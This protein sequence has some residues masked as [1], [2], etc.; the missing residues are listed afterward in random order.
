MLRSRQIMHNDVG[1][2]SKEAQLAGS[3]RD[4]QKPKRHR[5]R[6]LAATA[7]L[8]AAVSISAAGC[9]NSIT[10]PQPQATC[11]QPGTINPL[12]PTCQPN[13]T[14]QI[15][16]VP[17]TSIT[18]STITTTTTIPAS[19]PS[20][21]ERTNAVLRGWEDIFSHLSP[22]NVRKQIK[23][24]RLLIFL[25]A[26]GLALYGA[27]SGLLYA[28]RRFLASEK[29][30]ASTDNE[31]YLRHIVHNIILPGPVRAA[32]L[33]PHT[34]QDVLSYLAKHKKMG[35]AVSAAFNESISDSDFEK[36]AVRFGD[37]PLS[38]Q[39]KLFDSHLISLIALS[40]VLMTMHDA[41]DKLTSFLKYSPEEVQEAIYSKWRDEF[42]RQRENEK[43][44]EKLKS[45]PKAPPKLHYE[46]QVDS[47]EPPYP[48]F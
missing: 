20:S 3:L 37:Q 27:A 30:V 16:Y 36:I 23:E 12:L 34:P 32:A 41:G 31:D 25:G 21:K 44:L 9:S 4:T 13:N 45:M 42:I 48:E 22:S 35:L 18:S 26:A 39:L 29:A 5:I 40:E 38:T 10:P 15:P 2:E 33:N 1:L 19:P 28:K 11:D 6:S 46:P 8:G 43:Y 24:N 17:A 7:A 14:S 47:N